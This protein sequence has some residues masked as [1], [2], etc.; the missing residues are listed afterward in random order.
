M[1]A[2]TTR[3]AT[4]FQSVTFSSNEVDKN[5]ATATL[6]LV[7]ASPIATVALSKCTFEENNGRDDLGQSSANDTVWTTPVQ[8]SSSVWKL[9]AITSIPGSP[10]SASE[11]YSVNCCIWGLTILDVPS[12]RLLCMCFILYRNHACWV[13]SCSTQMTSELPR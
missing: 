12:S 1:P 5:N 10:M 2:V 7:F 6:P 3:G 11:R 13:C 8:L 4:T 9:V